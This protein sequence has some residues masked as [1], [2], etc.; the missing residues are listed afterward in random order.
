MTNPPDETMA[1]I[2]KAKEQ[3]SKEVEKLSIE[4]KIT[5]YSKR[6]KQE[7]TPSTKSDD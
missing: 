1:W 3:M 4:E 7:G 5:Y 6:A 2:W